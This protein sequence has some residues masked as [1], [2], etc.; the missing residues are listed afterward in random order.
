MLKA[1]KS[2]LTA[3]AD[4]IE[5]ATFKISKLFSRDSHSII[6]HSHIHSV[7]GWGNSFNLRRLPCPYF[8]IGGDQFFFGRPLPPNESKENHFSFSS[9]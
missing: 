7:K 9:D 4:Q 5:K 3:I 6:F 8:F 1:F 2:W